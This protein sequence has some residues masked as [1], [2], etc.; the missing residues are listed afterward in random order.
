MSSK[1]L[2]I[3]PFVAPRSS[4]EFIVTQRI[5]HGKTGQVFKARD[6]RSEQV[7]ALKVIP[8]SRILDSDVYAEQDIQASLDNGKTSFLVPLLASFHDSANY[9]LVTEFF[10][11]ND[12]SIHIGSSGKFEEEQARFYA[13]ELVAI[14][15]ELQDKCIIH[16]DIKP[17]NFMFTPQGHLRLIDFGC[18]KKFYKGSAPLVTSSGSSFFFDVQPEEDSGIFVLP[19]M[20]EVPFTASESVGTPAY[21]APAV[22]MGK[23]YSFEVDVHSVGV[24][25]F[26][27]LTG[28][29]PFGHGCTSLADVRSSV[30][31]GMVVFEDSDGVSEVAQDLVKRMLSKDGM[32]VEAIKAHPYFLNVPWDRVERQTLLPPRQPFIPASSMTQ[33]V[34]PFPIGEKYI[35]STDPKP[36]FSYVS[37]RLQDGY[38]RV[39][40]RAKQIGSKLSFLFDNVTGLNTLAPL[41]LTHATSMVAQLPPINSHAPP[42]FVPTPALFCISPSEPALALE[43]YSFDVDRLLPHAERRRGTLPSLKPE[44]EVPV[45]L[46]APRGKLPSQEVRTKLLSR[47]KS[48]AALRTAEKLEYRNIKVKSEVRIRVSEPKVK[49][50]QHSSPVIIM[51]RNEVKP[52][53]VQKKAMDGPTPRM[54]LADISNTTDR[55]QRRANIRRPPRQAAATTIKTLE[56]RLPVPIQ[57]IP[58]LQTVVC[59]PCPTV[60]EPSSTIIEYPEVPPTPRE[61]ADSMKSEFGDHHR[62]RQ[63]EGSNIGVQRP[64]LPMRKS[65]QL[66]HL[67]LPDIVKAR[68]S[69][70][71]FPDA[72]FSP[73]PSSK[74]KAELTRIRQ[75]DQPTPASA[76][77]PTHKEPVTNANAISSRA[78]QLHLKH[79]FACSTPRA[80]RLW[81]R[82]ALL[83]SR[84]VKNWMGCHDWATTRR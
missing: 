19:E 47:L 41:D 62:R 76:T 33:K 84:L 16:R 10:G 55:L 58:A 15:G 20:K 34:N 75:Y 78:R 14:L 50:V 59:E 56:S 79:Q 9:Y 5:G 42:T 67:H 72:S 69:A 45:D 43:D 32:T 73:A 21:M 36:F 51:P 80:R 22:H 74:T 44:E 8:K 46:R 37:P 61:V 26:Q 40:S 77:G 18:A 71:T 49:S 52:L 82:I 31:Q 30:L 63:D 28:R 54:P 70:P 1:M 65:V 17:A 68:P 6:V 64:S 48:G 12:L 81:I 11:G 29:L 53:R 66:R 23:A 83:V 7:V 3:A 4:A 38:H 60:I 25:L 24:M 2:S 13:A 57:V 39:P 27:M 35:P